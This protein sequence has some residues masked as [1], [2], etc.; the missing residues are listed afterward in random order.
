MVGKKL[1]TFF[2]ACEGP[3]VAK[4]L[5]IDQTFP[6]GEKNTIESD[7]A[8]PTTPKVATTI[9]EMIAQRKGSMVPLVSRFVS[10]RQFRAKFGLVSEKFTAMK[11][12]NVDYAA[13][14]ALGPVHLAYATDSYVE[15]EKSTRVDSYE[16]STESVYEEFPEV[17]ALLKVDLFEDVN[18][19]PILLIVS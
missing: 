12:K 8:K 10:K 18:A 19:Y 17:C 16:K 2:A 1:K 3:F 13:K 9:A 11:S 7:L 15:N 6:K 4:K 5:V 14:V